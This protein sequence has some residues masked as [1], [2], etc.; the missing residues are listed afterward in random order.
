[1]PEKRHFGR[2]SPSPPPPFPGRPADTRRYTWEWQKPRPAI[3]PPEDSF[4]DAAEQDD[5]RQREFWQ[6]SEDALAAVPQFLRMRMM[7]ALKT[8]TFT[9][10]IPMAQLKLNDRLRRD[11]PIV[12][13]VNTQHALNAQGLLPLSTNDDPI[14]WADMQSLSE[15]YNTLPSMADEE[16]ELLAQDIAIYLHGQLADLSEAADARILT[17]RRSCFMPRRP[18]S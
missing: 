2:Y 6:Q 12:S 1:M 5:K 10:G 4:T 3:S 13:A 18:P 9:K 16:I 15:R 17:I 11:V 8:T 7:R 14:H